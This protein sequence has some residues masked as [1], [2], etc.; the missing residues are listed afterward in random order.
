MKFSLFALALLLTGSLAMAD[1]QAPPASD[2]GPTRKLGRGLGNIAYGSS[3]ILDSIFS[4][5]YAEG[6]A[7]AF[8]YG[9]VRGVGRTFARLGYGVFEVLTFPFPT[10]RGTYYPPYLSDI[11]WINSGY[12]EFPPELG[13]E[14]RYP[15]NRFYQNTPW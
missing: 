1:I 9:V 2:Q 14:T 4:V 3:E 5:N 13:F 10:S 11:P 7:A 12:T 6:N 15:Y 8:S